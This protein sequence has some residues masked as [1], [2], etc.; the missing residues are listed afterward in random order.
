MKD[1]LKEESPKIL[2]FWNAHNILKYLAGAQLRK[3]IKLL[4]ADIHSRFLHSKF[5]GV[6]PYFKE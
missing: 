6:E 4:I 5:L 3:L 2:N 1:D